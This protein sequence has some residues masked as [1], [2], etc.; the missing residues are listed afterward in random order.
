[1][2]QKA[3]DIS[4]AKQWR[5]LFNRSF[6]HLPSHNVQLIYTIVYRRPYRSVTVNVIHRYIRCIRLKGHGIC[7]LDTSMLIEDEL[8][9][10]LSCQKPYIVAHVS[11]H[12][13]AI[14]LEN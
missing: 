6:H 3:C 2:S 9:G 13:Y 11:H 4:L 12:L 7:L 1:M 10:F 14:L 8:V 5:E